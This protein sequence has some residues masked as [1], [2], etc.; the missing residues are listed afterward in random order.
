[1]APEEEF[2]PPKVVV[3]ALEYIVVEFHMTG[4]KNEVVVPLVAAGA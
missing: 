1:M 3:A 2:V 4:M